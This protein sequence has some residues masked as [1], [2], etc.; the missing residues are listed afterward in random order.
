LANDNRYVYDGLRVIQERDGSNNPTVVYTRGSDLSGTFEGAGGIGGLLARSHAYQSGSGSFTNHN[1]YHADGGGNITYMVNSSQ[2]M[3]AAYRYDPYGNL[4]SS[5]G[6]LASTNTY[7]F[8]SKEG[9]INANL[10]YYGYRSYDPNFQRWLNRDP[11]GD[12]AIQLAI[13]R[14][15]EPIFDALRAEIS[16]GPNLFTF[17]ANRPGFYIDANGLGWQ[18]GGMGGGR[19]CNDTKNPVYA[20]I[21]S[22]YKLVCPKG[23]TSAW[24]DDVDGFWVGGHF[25]AVTGVNIGSEQASNPSHNCWGCPPPPPSPYPRGPGGGKEAS[26]SPRGRG[27]PNDDPPPPQRCPP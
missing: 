14:H 19:V 16:Q 3:V 10:Y 15:R 9:L 7:R 24:S 8:S 13:V 21:D 20:L 5:S 1:L 27:A 18:P 22:K 23:C 2:S 6:T 11:L 12:I 25:Y 17:V 4:I 26:C